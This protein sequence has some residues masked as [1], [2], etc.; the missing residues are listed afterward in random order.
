MGAEIVTVSTDSKYVHLA[1]QRAERGLSAVKFPMG[2][3][4]TGNLA[5]LFGVYNA[6]TGQALRGTFII[7]P[8]GILLSKE[9]NFDNVGRNIDELMRKFKAFLHVARHPARACPSKWK[10]ET[11]QTLEPSP[12]LVGAVYERDGELVG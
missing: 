5:R 1:W 4:Q 6:D 2:S 9:V 3:D 8:D 7:N 11:D 10:E 12:K